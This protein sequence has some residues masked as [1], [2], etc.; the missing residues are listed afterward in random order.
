M[1]SMGTASRQ[2]TLLL[3][4]ALL[5]V[6][7]I[8]FT[9]LSLYRNLDFQG[10]KGTYKERLFQTLDVIS[11]IFPVNIGLYRPQS[12]SFKLLYVEPTVNLTH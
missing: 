10:Q 4:I 8:S 9:T 6:I 7:F 1:F 12:C 3:G 2:S 5:F 11:T